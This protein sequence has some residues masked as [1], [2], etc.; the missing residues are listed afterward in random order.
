V[1]TSP[2]GTEAQ[3]DPL[4]AGPGAHGQPGTLFVLEGIDRSGRSTHIRRLEEHLRY[5]G[6]GV[7]R[8]SS[9]SSSLSGDRIRR[10]RRD[11]RPDPIETALLYAA[12][13]AERVEQVVIPALRAGMIVIADRYCWTP[14]ARAAARG[15]DPAWLA[16]AFGFVPPPDAVLF[17]DVD[18]DASLARRP[19]DP[20]PYEAGLDLGLSPDLRESYRLF[21]MRLYACFDGYADQAGFTRIKATASVEQVGQRVLR[22]TDAVLALRA[23]TAVA[24]ASAGV[25][26]SPPAAG[27]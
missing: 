20:D 9:A 15:V 26:A 2:V 25:P 10:A 8:T 16:A 1:L 14:M 18:A 17:L 3:G 12:D 4:R 22:T 23:A 11:R 7:T 13:L 24:G 21:Q 27:R 19:E 5:A 6:H